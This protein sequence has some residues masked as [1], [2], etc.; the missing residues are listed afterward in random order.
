MIVV[1]DY[2]TVPVPERML[3]WLRTKYPDSDQYQR[4]SGHMK[5]RRQYKRWARDV[6]RIEASLMLGAEITWWEGA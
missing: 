2:G 5:R 1:T 4:A 6:E 3:T